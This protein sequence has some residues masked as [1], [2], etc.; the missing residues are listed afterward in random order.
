MDLPQGPVALLVAPAGYGK[1]A[2]LSEWAANDQRPFAWVS[3]KDDDNDPRELLYH[4]ACALDPIEPGRLDALEALSEA[5]PMVLALDDLHVL[6]E[7]AALVALGAI[8]KVLPPASQL[9]LASRTDSALPVGRLRA[10][11]NVLEL[12][13]RDLA[14]TA[15]EA[16]ALFA[17]H[18][19][20]LDTG[21]VS[22]LAEQT[23]GWP[24]GLY[25]AALS[26]GSQSNV[27]EGV[28]RFAGDG[29][30]VSDYV[31]DEILSGLS[32]DQLE[33]V[34]R[35]A[36][37][38]RLSGPLCDAILD[39]RGS[40][41]MLAELARSNV[42]LVPLD[43]GDHSYRYNR[44]LREMLRS[45]LAR[46]EP[47]REAELRSRASAWFEDNG[48][49]ERAIEHAVE[50][51]DV[52]RAGELMWRNVCRYTGS[53]RDAVVRAW[54][55][56]FT[57]T[58]I[59]SC[60]P[61]GL[62]AA[63]SHLNAGDGDQAERWTGVAAA[64][65]GRTPRR[66]RDATVEAGLAMMRA[67][68][69]RDGV[70]RMAD[71]AALAYRLEPDGSLRR[72][73]CRLI[74]GVACH[75]GGDLERARGY[76]EEGMRAA[77]VQTPAIHALCLA[78]LTLLAL[79]EDDWDTGAW[80]AARAKALVKRSPN[81][82]DS[83]MAALVLAVSAAARAQRGRVE[84]AR[85]DARR[86]LHLLAC[87][88][89]FAAWYEC[90]TRIVLAR[91]SLRLSDARL[92]KRLLAEASRLLR[93]V[94][95]APVLRRWLDEAWLQAAATEGSALNDDWSLTTAE[96]RVLQFLPSHLSF[97]QIAERL[98]VSPNTVKTHVRALYRKLQA[99][100]RG[101]AVERAQRSGLLDVAMP[102]AG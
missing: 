53:G 34:V 48:D 24:A 6:H 73:I 28:E 78:Q 85:D 77:A 89:N 58:Q 44:L 61:L 69:A 97:P 102:D 15:T 86:A 49:T 2:L 36:V 81:V 84:E 65:F 26:V 96:L 100:S 16:G 20:E 46:F 39:S 37:L 42:L 76:L 57:D 4:V 55:A 67:G 71:D 101:Q 41:T 32:A 72:P 13:A 17:V 12:R 35:T 82:G 60:P 83:P 11:G 70:D 5:E 8:G 30:Y 50:A 56:R 1:T 7:P 95:D 90:E 52:Q 33:F 80:Y 63:Q 99:S 87:S 66:E 3:L 64:G 68:L 38:D 22:A 23:E 88:T 21:E 62:V 14:M 51:A 92:A 9:A 29:L 79:D 98:Y 59:A 43:E 91:A 75:L 18:G 10:Q 31:R 27:H 25:L 54:L 47:E 93:Q 19:V 45:E 74:E 94:P 40:A